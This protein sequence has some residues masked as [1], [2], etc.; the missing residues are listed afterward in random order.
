[1][2]HLNKKTS[3]EFLADADEHLSAIESA[4]LRLQKDGGSCDEATAAGL[5][6]SLQAVQSCAELYELGKAR[7]LACHMED[8][9]LRIRSRHMLLTPQRVAENAAASEQ[10]D[11]D[12]ALNALTAI[13][14]PRNDSIHSP[15]QLRFLLAEDDFASRMVMHTFLSRYGSCDVA[16][17]GREATESFRLALEQDRAYHLVCLDIMM[18][19]VDGL[20]TIRLLRELEE[21]RGIS[22]TQGAKIIM[23]TAV[24]ELSSVSRCFMELCDAYLTKP[25]DLSRLLAQIRAFQL[26]A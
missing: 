14:G 25:I 26:I 21:A 18:P 17:N 13:C 9:L 11:T 10:V 6:Q 19:E 24:E 1:M 3:Q 8:A 23:T 5:I 12:A 22:S 15:E 20:Q 7:E 16:I 2:P 4:L